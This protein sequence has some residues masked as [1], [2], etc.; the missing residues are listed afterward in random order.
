MMFQGTPTLGYHSKQAAIVAL[1]EQGLP[2]SVIAERL[3]MNGRDFASA[4]SRALKRMG[5]RP[6]DWGRIGQA[7]QVRL[8]ARLVEEIMPHAE[9]RGCTPNELARRIVEAAIDHDLVAAVLDDGVAALEAA[10]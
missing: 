7:W 3:G 10:E 5:R 4:K 1:V 6:R 9:A 2:N 8:P